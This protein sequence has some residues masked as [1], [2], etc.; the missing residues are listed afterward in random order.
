MAICPNCVEKL[1]KDR[2]RLGKNSDWLVCPICGY[3]TREAYEI[4]DKKMEEI[5]YSQ[6]QDR[7]DKERESFSN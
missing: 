2:K 4:M 3:R 6:Y 5:R 1:V 7:L